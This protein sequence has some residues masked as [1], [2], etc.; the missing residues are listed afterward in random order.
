M[1]RCTAGVSAAV[2]ALACAVCVPHAS[3]QDVDAE[4][5]S[6]FEKAAQMTDEA[7][8][9]ARDAL[10]E[11]GRE[12]L[13]FLRQKTEGE[14]WAER[15]LARA[16]IMRFEQPEYV[17]LCRRAI[18]WRATLTENADGTFT[19]KLNRDEATLAKRDGRPIPPMD[20]FVLTAECVPAYV[21]MLREDTQVGIGTR[22]SPVLEHFP[23]LN[24]VPA[25]VNLVGSHEMLRDAVA[26]AVAAVGKPALPFL[27]ETIRNCPTEYARGELSALRPQMIVAGAAAQAISRIGDQEAVPLLI[28]KLIAATDALQVEPYAEALGRL[29]DPEAVRIVFDHL[30]RPGLVFRTGKWRLKRSPAYHALREAM[31]LFGPAA[32]EFLR[33][34]TDP[35]RP[36]DEQMI[37]R[38][39]LFDIEHPDDAVRIYVEYYRQHPPLEP[40]Q[41][42]GRGHFAEQTRVEEL[43]IS[44]VR[45]RSW[46]NLF[47][48]FSVELPA[49]FAGEVAVIAPVEDNLR[50]LLRFRDELPVFD[51][52]ADALLSGHVSNWKASALLL[53][54]LGDVRAVDVFREQLRGKDASYHAADLLEPLLLLGKKEA[55]PL[56]EEIAGL[57]VCERP[58]CQELRREGK[59]DGLCRACQR[60]EATR[61]MAEAILP[62]LR[63]VKPDADT[64]VPDG[65]GPA[66]HGRLSSLPVLI[67]LAA[68]S[69]RDRHLLFRKA[70]MRLGPAAIDALTA[71]GEASED[72][73]EKLLCEALAL[74]LREPALAEA[75]DTAG[76]HRTPGLADD[77]IP[78]VSDFRDCGIKL[79]EA[80]GEKSVA[81][82]EAAVAFEADTAEFRIAV[83]ALG[84]L[85][86]ERSI[87]VITAPL[88]D[89]GLFRSE[90][91]VTVLAEYGEKGID[92]IVRALERL[93][94]AEE[95]ASYNE[96]RKS[97]EFYLKA[98][99]KS[100]N[101]RLLEAVIEFHTK[102]A[103]KVP[104]ELRPW[105]SILRVLAEYE[106]ERVVPICIGYLSLYETHGIMDAI[107]D[108]LLI[109]L[110]EGAVRVLVKTLA[111]HES[112]KVRAGAAYC[113]LSLASGHGW[114]KTAVL[115]QQRKQAAEKTKTAVE[116]L[117]AALDDKSLEVQ[118]A[119]AIALTRI[120]TTRDGTITDARPVEPLI[121][122]LKHKAETEP[123]VFDVR[124]LP[125]ADNPSLR[126][127]LSP[128]AD[129]L[130]KSGN[131][132]VGPAL[133]MAYRVSRGTDTPLKAL[134]KT[135]Y[136]EA[137]PDIIKA[138]DA[139]LEA[140]DFRSGMPELEAAA[141]M[142]GKGLAKVYEIF[143]S[144][145]PMSVR[146]K[147]AEALSKNGYLEAFDAIADLM[148]DIAAAGVKDP[149]E[150]S[151]YAEARIGRWQQQI[152]SLA[153]SLVELDRERARPL[154]VKM[155]PECDNSDLERAL[156]RLIERS[157]P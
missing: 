157:V 22:V 46:D 6:R 40:S 51:I 19:V 21:E 43:D 58:H 16:M 92:H 53:A 64:S 139:R 129:Y 4:F 148:K 155:I 44:V 45:S 18:K 71:Y 147:A 77:M 62:I 20:D 31:C 82:A 50:R 149:H 123:H 100:H 30:I 91:A 3:G 69:T 61:E 56:V 84:H 143:N 42:P 65:D 39:L 93:I 94:P 36:I 48:R 119:A 112:D 89:T 38:G 73:R 133:H 138:L 66:G 124:R 142:G 107:T 108:P 98:A 90:C 41:L 17:E 97:T 102:V 103:E 55:V 23:S 145:L 118:K 25:L 135:G 154:I 140:K 79:A 15:D 104:Q 131:P 80:V 122:W 137:L 115:P 49:A 81:L 34:R 87:P 136:T 54:E 109:R 76:R 141:A 72:W 60:Q 144:D 68:G 156:A 111:Q 47:D 99:G 13:P 153:R 5:A 27:R 28:G 128:I 106:D 125:N 78:S 116:P 75:F 114:R 37:A 130:V 150:K 10:L 126:T 113:L 33:E 88:D 70:I 12:V 11:A 85:K 86:Q 59:K 1:E 105:A 63:D 83:F 26:D 57:V 120:T 74:R 101:G 132:N 127:E 95:V 14:K 9:V 134:A 151:I 8:K 7:Y 2:L 24:S 35:L 96:W 117:I 52:I 29:G 146:I 110:G 121:A 32:R 152:M 67:P